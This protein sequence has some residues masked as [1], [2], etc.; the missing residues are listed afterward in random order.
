MRRTHNP[1]LPSVVRV[2]D[3]WLGQRPRSRH[4]GY[5][6]TTHVKYSAFAC[7]DRSRPN[8]YSHGPFRTPEHTRLVARL[9]RRRSF[10]CS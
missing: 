3:G 10:R 5:T 2:D 7:I 9:F 4:W 6:P 1:V 8:H